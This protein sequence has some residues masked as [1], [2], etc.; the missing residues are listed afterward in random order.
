MAPTP[1]RGDIKPL[2]KYEGKKKMLKHK[3]EP[4]EIEAMT[5]TMTQKTS[6]RSKVDNMNKMKAVKDA[7]SS[8]RRTKE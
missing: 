1:R 3:S 6:S 4:K 5:K 2:K 8:Q 7:P